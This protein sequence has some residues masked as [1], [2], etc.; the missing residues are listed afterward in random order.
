[1]TIDTLA[2]AKALE[3][4]GLDRRDAETQV[5]ALAV[6]VLPDI[7]TKDDLNQANDRVDHELKV[8][9]D[10]LKLTIGRT[11][12]QQSWRLFGMVFAVV[13]LLD[14]ILFALLRVVPPPH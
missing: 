6:H 5:A 1:M 13:G 8:T 9:R 10:E 3:A 4:A 7:V 12:H 11:V 14:G 2:Y